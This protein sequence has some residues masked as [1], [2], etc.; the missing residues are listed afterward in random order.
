M[1]R[2]HSNIGML[3]L[4]PLCIAAIATAAVPGSRQSFMPPPSSAATYDMTDGMMYPSEQGTTAA[5]SGI[6]RN[7]GGGGG[8]TNS[9][10]ITD[11]ITFQ[12]ID[13]Y[14]DADRQRLMN[15][16]N[17]TRSDL[18]NRVAAKMNRSNANT[19]HKPATEREQQ[20]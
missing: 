19:T 7:S 4:W 20:K 2:P 3:W 11:K 8:G 16:F 12:P 18:L 15:E 1:I 9:G 14:D 13:I 6:N 10:S 5:Q 17:L